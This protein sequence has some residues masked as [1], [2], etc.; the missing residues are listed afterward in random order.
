M[1]GGLAAG[2]RIHELLREQRE[3]VQDA[4]TDLRRRCLGGELKALSR[5]DLI[6]TTAWIDLKIDFD[7]GVPFVRR[8]G[9]RTRDPA[10][11]NISFS[12]DETLRVFRPAETSGDIEVADAKGLS[13]RRQWRTRRAD[14]FNRKQE[15]IALEKRVWLRLTEIADEYARKSGS[16]TI[17]DEKREQF[18]MSCGARFWRA[19]SWMIKVGP[20]F[21]TGI[22]Q[23]LRIFVSS[24]CRHATLSYLI[25]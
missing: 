14:R 24:L 7:E 4:A 22:H 17:E 3:Q 6:P 2:V 25:R 12:R 23:S 1:Y 21:S 8:V 10:Y 19:N 18:W 13:L 5:Q 20:A 11:D 16:L 15:R 9:Q